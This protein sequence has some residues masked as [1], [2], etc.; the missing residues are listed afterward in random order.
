M[1][2]KAQIQKQ[3]IRT[4]NKQLKEEKIVDLKREKETLYK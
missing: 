4:D 2:L 1:E 3:L